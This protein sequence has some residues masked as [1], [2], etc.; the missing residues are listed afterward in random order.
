MT[1]ERKEM[2]NLIKQHMFAMLQNFSLTH[3]KN[4]NQ[5]WIRILIY[6]LYVI[7]AY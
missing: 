5:Q 3:C 2:I 4:A 7:D 6:V 1:I